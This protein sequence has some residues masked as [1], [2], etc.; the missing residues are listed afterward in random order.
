MPGAFIARQLPVR[1]R[2]TED[3]KAA[4]GPARLGGACWELDRH[5]L[6][7]RCQEGWK[8]TGSTSKQDLD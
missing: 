2:A 7:Q 3:G 8:H 6:A 4:V 1:R 5:G